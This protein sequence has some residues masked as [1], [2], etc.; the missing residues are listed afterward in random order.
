MFFFFP[1]LFF[2]S[3]AIEIFSLGTIYYFFFSPLSSP[4]PPVTAD[5][6]PLYQTAPSL[7]ESGDCLHLDGWMV[8]PY[9]LSLFPKS[10]LGILS[11]PPLSPLYTPG[12]GVNQLL[13][14]PF[15]FGGPQHPTFNRE[16]GDESAANNIPSGLRVFAIHSSTFLVL[17]P[18]WTR[19][20]ER[21][22]VV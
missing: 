3:V 19:V 15:S 20:L 18:R 8:L 13:A 12:I 1:F 4:P 16:A 7:L 22:Y 2:F 5:E 9:F 10:I 11:C 14:L 21:S 17:S 6:Q